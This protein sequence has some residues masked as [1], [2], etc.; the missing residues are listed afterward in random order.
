MWFVFCSGFSWHWWKS[1]VARTTWFPWKRRGPGEY[2]DQISLTCWNVVMLSYYRGYRGHEMMFLCL[3]GSQG[4]PG[5][6][7]DQV[8]N[9]QSPALQSFLV[10][11]WTK[12]VFCCSRV[13]L[14]WQGH[15]G[16]RA[17]EVKGWAEWSFLTLFLTLL[18]SVYNSFVPVWKRQKTLYVFSLCFAD[19][20]G[21]TGLN[22]IWRWSTWEERGARHPRNTGKKQI[23]KQN[24]V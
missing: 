15:K 9:S 3:Q 18:T 11:I 24:T 1:R 10:D 16:K 7:G 4:L 5:V 19:A 2:R 14:V 6:R 21:W 20:S 8:S 23:G 13:D 17:K 22:Y 12:V